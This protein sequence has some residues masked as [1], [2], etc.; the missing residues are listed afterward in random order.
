MSCVFFEGVGSC[1]VYMLRIVGERKPPFGIP[2][3]NWY[4]VDTVFLKI[5]FP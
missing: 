5:T 3:L 4:C 1:E 2:V